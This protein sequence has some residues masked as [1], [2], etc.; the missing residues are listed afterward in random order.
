MKTR[1][2]K[3]ITAVFCASLAVGCQKMD[4]PVLGSY[5]KD[6]NTPGGPLKFFAAFDG[7]SKDPLMNAVD[8]IRANFPSDNP[9]EQT[10][11]VSGRG[12]KGIN[13]KFLKYA[14]PND[15]AATAESF[16]VSF[17]YKRDGQT[18]NNIGKN[19]PEYILS[20]KSSNNHWSGGNFLIFLEGNNTACA[21]KVMAVDAEGKE[22][23]FTWEEEQSIP[24]I[25]DNKWH[26]IA[27]VYNAASSGVTLYLDG[28]AN[29]NIKSWAAH[30]NINFDDSKISEFRVGAGPG[31]EY[32]TDDW[33]SSTW[34]GDIDQLRLYTTPFTAPEI[35]GIFAGKK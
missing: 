2:N 23:W 16:T 7:T 20:F 25:M 31:T 13:Q 3:I 29:P 19:G 22:N 24:G 27:L 30:G 34:K 33:L 26:H 17:W 1:I 12:L 35:S 5:P 28:T 11:G 15:W 6:T 8:S 14:K 4:H 10:E 21:V 18:L 32:A 9:L